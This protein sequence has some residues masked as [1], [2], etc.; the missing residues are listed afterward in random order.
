MPTVKFDHSK[1]HLFEALG[2]RGFM[3]AVD[4]ASHDFKR[5]F[6][7]LVRKNIEEG[8]QPTK[9]FPPSL[10]VEYLICAIRKVKGIRLSQP[11]EIEE[12]LEVLVMY[13][14]VSHVSDILKTEL[15]IKMAKDLMKTQFGIDLDDHD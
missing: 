4:L 7:S 15:T 5:D 12:V 1:E 11:Y 6:S 14:C 9:G 10:L 2:I 13:Q 8:N 3:P